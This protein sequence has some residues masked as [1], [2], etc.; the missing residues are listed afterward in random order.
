MIATIQIRLS[1]KASNHTQTIKNSISNKI[2]IPVQSINDIRIIRRSLDAR[3]RNIQYNLTIEYACNSIQTLPKK[4]ILF[5]RQQVD[6]AEEVH[7]IGCGPA[8]LFAA[9]TLIEQGYK[10]IILERG[11][12]VEKRKIDIAMLHQNKDVREHSNY[13]FGEGGAGTFSDGKLYTRSKKKGDPQRILDL[14]CLHG[15]NKQI[16]IDAHPHIGTDKLPDII[17]NIRQTILDCGG[18]IHFS[19]HV[20]GFKTE[21]NRISELILDSNTTIAVK[22]VILASGHSA[23]DVYYA[24]HESGI[25][26]ESKPTAMGV[27]VEHPQEFINNNQYHGVSSPYLPPAEYS[28]AHTS[29]KGV[30]SFCMCPGGIIVPASTHPQQLV[31]NG[32]SNSLRNS[33]FANSGI[34]V[35]LDEK[36]YEPFKE[37]GVFAGLKFQEHLESLAFQNGGIN[38]QAPAQRISDFMSKKISQNL[39][40]CSYTPG[41]ISSPLHFW[42]PEPIAEKLQEAFKVFNKRIRGFASNDG[43]LVGVESRTSSP[44]R[45]PREPTR[46]HHEDIINLYPCG[47]G[48]GYAGGI[49]SSATDGI[50]CALAITQNK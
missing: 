17:K 41:I 6:S 9:L 42:L 31:V 10:P 8:G 32:M 40:E 50:N 38:L 34:V 7:I 37:H 49:V 21:N 5:N 47:E 36:D 15:A 46:L 33:K 20:S 1:P 2:G 45:I 48:A 18:E 27:R 11:K 19:T 29:D 13:S 43:I 3:S 4:E 35:S 30:Y 14:L 16:S 26:I 23:R 28:L 12:T 25:R 39:P 24:L 22:Q 44:I